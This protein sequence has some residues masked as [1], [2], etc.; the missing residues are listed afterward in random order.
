MNSLPRLIVTRGETSGGTVPLGSKPF[1]IGR[2]LDNDLRLDDLS[3]SGYHA[4]LIPL[5]NDMILEDL[6]S[7]NGTLV[8]DLPIRKRVLC[9]G[10]R[11][12]IGSHELLFTRAA[13]KDTPAEGAS[14]PR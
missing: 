4:Q 13:P 8:N 2:R 11:I 9:E 6:N 10:D 3:V 12:A 5:L 14:D 1:T 7:T